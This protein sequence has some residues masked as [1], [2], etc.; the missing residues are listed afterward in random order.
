MTESMYAN[1]NIQ[2]PST[3][4]VSETKYDTVVLLKKTLI[5][6][7]HTDRLEMNEK[8]KRRKVVPCKT[9]KGKKPYRY[10][11]L[12]CN[13]VSWFGRFRFYYS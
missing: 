2:K 12:T 5:A 4:A 3:G 10:G 9:K 6:Q 7:G 11:L 8:K 1:S 13:R